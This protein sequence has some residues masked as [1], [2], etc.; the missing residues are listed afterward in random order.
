MKG[1]LAFMMAAGAM[2]ATVPADAAERRQ[3]LSCAGA[4]FSLA[5]P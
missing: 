2:V 3:G 5:C 1:V 4:R